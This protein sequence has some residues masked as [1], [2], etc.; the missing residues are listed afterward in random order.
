M[1]PIRYIRRFVGVLAGLTAALLVAT[2]AFARDVPNPPDAYPGRIVPTRVP[3]SVPAQIQYRTIVA[4]GMPGWQ[5]TLI[6]LGAALVA[7]AATLLLARIV[8][9]HR[10]APA[11]NG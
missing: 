11:T 2:P 7:V 8:A 10:A 1:N 3:A 4:G 9:A 5:I 6:A